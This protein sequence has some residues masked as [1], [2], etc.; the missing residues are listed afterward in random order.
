MKT[1]KLLLQEELILVSA[2]QI[3]QVPAN[4]D[5]VLSVLPSSLSELDRVLHIYLVLLADHLLKRRLN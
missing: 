4:F 2:D 5:L 3:A 1:V